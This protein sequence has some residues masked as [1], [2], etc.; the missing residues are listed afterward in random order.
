MALAIATKRNVK[1]FPVFN[2]LPSQSGHRLPLRERM[3]L[4]LSPEAVVYLERLIDRFFQFHVGIQLRTAE[5]LRETL[6]SRE[7]LDGGGCPGDTAGPSASPEAAVPASGALA[8]NEG[9]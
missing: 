7:N 1:D 6:R 5:F 4:G 8:G 3:R 9:R 2:A